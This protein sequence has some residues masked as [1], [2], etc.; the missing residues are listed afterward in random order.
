MKVEIYS[1][2]ACPWC[3]IGTRRFMRAMAEFEHADEVEVTTLPYQ[4]DPTLPDTAEPLR[5]RLAEKFGPQTDA[6]L[7]RTASVARQEGLT[8]DWDKAQ[9]VNTFTAHRLLRLARV[10]Y[11]AD[12]LLALADKLFAAHFSEG[13]DVSDHALL[14]DFAADVGMDRDRVAAYLESGEGTAEVRAEIDRAT[15]IGVRAVPTF[16]FDGTSAIQ[17]AQPTETFLEALRSVRATYLD[18]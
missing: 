18:A 5:E 7:G 1:D 12:V 11:G 15:R 10:E 14:A 3:Y 9:S 17:G 2:I 13:R 8:F 6:M 4:L 16:V